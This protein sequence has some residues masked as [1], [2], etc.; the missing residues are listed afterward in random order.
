MPMSRKNINT[1]ATG[2]RRTHVSSSFNGT[3]Q[4]LRFATLFSIKLYFRIAV[5]LLL[6]SLS[7]LSLAQTLVIDINAVSYTHLTLPTILLV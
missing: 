2:S 4:N 5:L 1:L 3:S 7:N 6:H